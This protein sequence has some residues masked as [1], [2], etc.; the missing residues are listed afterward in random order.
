MLAIRYTSQYARDEKRARK[1]GL[2]T[3][4][5]DEVLQVLREQKPLAPKHRDHALAGELS[6]FRECH[7]QPDW[8]LVWKQEDNN[9]TL[10]LTN[11]GTHS[12][13]FG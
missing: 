2:P 13:I 10:L 7:I 9:L 1:R 5:L 3:R 4:L 8:L 11:T 12:Y 6:G